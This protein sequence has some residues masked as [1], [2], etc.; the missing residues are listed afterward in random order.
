MRN[1]LL[2]LLLATVNAATPLLA[3][4]MLPAIVGN[5]MVLQQKQTNPIWGWDTPGARVT[6]NFAGQNHSA[7]AGND[8]RWSVKLAPL[9][10]NATPQTMSIAG[11]SRVEIEDVLIGE[12]WMCSGQSNMGFTL[13]NDWNGPL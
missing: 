13:A 4:L 10:A 9:P 12:V 8:G 6:V 11:T 1:L 7:T 2:I 3:G 5:H